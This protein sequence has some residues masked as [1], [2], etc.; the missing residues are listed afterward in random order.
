[1][2]SGLCTGALDARAREGLLAPSAQR[3]ADWLG[4]DASWLWPDPARPR[5]VPLEHRDVPTVELPEEAV[6]S[7]V[8]VE[9]K[10]RRMLLGLS[11][12]ERQVLE[13]RVGPLKSL[14]S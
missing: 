11:A 7:K 6:L 4:L 1:M 3:L 13:L 2:L 5:R 12:R 10:L 9:R 8:G 14:S